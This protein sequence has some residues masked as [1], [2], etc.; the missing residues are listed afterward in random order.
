VQ[1]SSRSGASTTTKLRISP[2]FLGD[3]ASHATVAFLTLSAMASVAD[4]IYFPSLE[5]CL[6]GERVLL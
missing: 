5:Q 1:A 3:A 6:T 4:R 2:H